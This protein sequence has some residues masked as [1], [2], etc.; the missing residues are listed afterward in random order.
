MAQ[1]PRGA[2]EEPF[3]GRSRRPNRNAT[4][5]REQ[6]N[7]A[8]ARFVNR[9]LRMAAMTH[10]GFIAGGDLAEL[11]A[12]LGRAPGDAASIE[13][14]RTVEFQ[15]ERLRQERLEAERAAELDHRADQERQRMDQERIEA[16]LVLERKCEEQERQRMDQE[17]VEAGL[18]RSVE[19][20]RQRVER[21]CAEKARVVERGA[22]LDANA[23]VWTPAHIDDAEQMQRASAEAARKLER[24]QA[25]WCDDGARH[26]E[27]KRDR[28]E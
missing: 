8:T 18:R 9:V 24:S 1:S 22:V 2:H 4:H 21:E 27:A 13:A 6:A 7:R 19:L 3:V 11:A 25:A 26:V 20:E 16:E 5:R 10:R 12:K 17:R 28:Q 15:R 14:E 23:A